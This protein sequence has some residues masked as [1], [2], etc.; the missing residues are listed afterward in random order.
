MTAAPQRALRGDRRRGQSGPVR[1]PDP[2]QRVPRVP[3]ED[4]VPL[5]D[6]SASGTEAKRQPAGATCTAHPASCPRSSA[7]HRRESQRP[8]ASHS[9]APAAR[10]A[11]VREAG[12]R[13]VRRRFLL[14]WPL[15]QGRPSGPAA[16]GGSSA[17]HGG[18]RPDVGSCR[19]AA[20]P[21][22]SGRTRPCSVTWDRP[23]HAP[24]RPAPAS[25]YPLF[26]RAPARL[27]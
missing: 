10:A 20:T 18:R 8:G 21:L 22:S 12:N 3:G 17:S 27:P 15:G 2:L 6:N 19:G 7:P 26:G 16:P 13:S 5:R 11:V 9:P 25:C 14:R 4:T 23:F 24:P 1:D